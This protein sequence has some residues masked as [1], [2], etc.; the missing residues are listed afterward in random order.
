[1]GLGEKAAEAVKEWKFKPG[2]MEGQP[3]E[4]IFDL[5]V[6]FKMD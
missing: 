4:V 3:V 5:T 6:N 1:M 2:T